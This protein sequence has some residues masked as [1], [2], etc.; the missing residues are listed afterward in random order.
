M[1]EGM[2]ARLIEHNNWANRAITRACAALEDAQLDARPISE[3]QWSIRENLV[4]LVV[5]QQDYL[6]ML[7]LPAGSAEPEAPSF[8]EL[9]ASVDASGAGLLALDVDRIPGPLD[10]GEGYRVEPWVVMLQ[11]VNHATEHRKQIANLM[12][13]QGLEPPRLDGWAY[14]EAE[15]ALIPPLGA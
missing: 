9:E 4:H 2:L 12:R 15:R 10:I 7:T 3:K 5:C 1:V 14:G 13:A 8:A 6:R 11:A